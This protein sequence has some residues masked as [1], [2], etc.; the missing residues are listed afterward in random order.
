MAATVSLDIKDL[1]EAGL[2]GYVFKTNLFI[3]KQLDEPN[4]CITVLDAPGEPPE[5]TFTFKKGIQILV[6]NS[7]YLSGYGAAQEVM[8]L[9]NSFANTVIDIRRYILIKA[10]GD[11][12]PLGYDK[13]KNRAMFSINFLVEISQ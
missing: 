12:I 7:S 4:N 8:N 10:E 5:S 2:S 1:I 13:S 6:R 9:L 3:G 11:I